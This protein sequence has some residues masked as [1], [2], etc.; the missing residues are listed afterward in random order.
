MSHSAKKLERVF[1]E[2]LI[3]TYVKIIKNSPPNVSA[4][5]KIYI[6]KFEVQNLK[7]VISALNA[8]M[9]S[10]QKASRVYFSA[11]DFLKDRDAFDKAIKASDYETLVAAM[12]GTDYADAMEEGLKSYEEG[13]SPTCF[14]VLIDKMFYEKIYLNY[15]KLPRKE[16]RHVR[17]YAETESASYI[18]TMILRAKALGFDVDWLRVAVPDSHFLNGEIVETLVTA[19]DFEAALNLARKTS[20]GKFFVKAQV[21]EDTITGAEKAFRKTIYEHALKSRIPETFNVGA[22]LSFMY[23]KEAEIQN[24]IAITLGIEANLEKEEI[25]RSLLL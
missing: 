24:L 3:E 6:Q 20:F 16:K 18:I 8:E 1:R 21:P 4:F 5:L 11:E 22:A 17:F 12:K 15:E 2:N 10:T 14:D 13:G 25:K 23:Q 9:S 7:A 19:T